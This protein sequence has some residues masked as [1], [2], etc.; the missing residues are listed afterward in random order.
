MKYK[1]SGRFLCTLD[2]M[3]G[4]FIAPVVIGSHE[5]AVLI[6]LCSGYVQTVFKAQKRKRIEVVNAGCA[7]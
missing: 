4:Y 6:P 5:L 7:R 2:P 3:K 1:K